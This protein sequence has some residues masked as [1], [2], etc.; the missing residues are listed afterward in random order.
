MTGVQTCALP[1][2]VRDAVG[3]KDVEC[4]GG[5]GFTGY[6]VSNGGVQK[7]TW[8]KEGG[9]GEKSPLIFRDENGDEIRVNRGKSYIAINYSSQTTFQ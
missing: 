5:P 1:I 8:A 7:I 2:S 9:M 6:Y 4:M 3:H